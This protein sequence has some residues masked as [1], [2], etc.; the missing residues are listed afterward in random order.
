M[1][2]RNVD[3]N[4]F[5]ESNPEWLDADFDFSKRNDPDK[6]CG[7]LYADLI[8]RFFPENRNENIKKVEH[9]NNG[10]NQ[11]YIVINDTIYLTSDYIGPSVNW[12]KK[13]GNC[14]DLEIKD[15][16]KISRTIGGHLTWPVF[17]GKP[18]INTARGGSNGVFDRIDWT[19]LLLKIY[20]DLHIGKNQTYTYF[21]YFFQALKS[22]FD[23]QV[24]RRTRRN[25]YAKLDDIYP[26]FVKSHI[27]LNLFK[28]FEGFC[29]FFKLIGNFVDENYK[30][31]ELAPYLPVKPTPENYKEYIRKSICAIIKRN[32]AL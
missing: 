13:I 15:I 24:K 23:C 17:I 20:Y 7:S 6:N 1:T 4:Y 14:N 29:D 9:S 3:Y 5:Q 8:H 12:A 11:H 22:K 30:V 18:T 19:L 32:K 26:A 27:Y 25:D 2:H 16:L 10:D 28:S 31:I 21:D